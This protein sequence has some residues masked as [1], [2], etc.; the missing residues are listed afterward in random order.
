MARWLRILIIEL[1]A[2]FTAAIIAILENA[3]T[4]EQHPKHALIWGLVAF[5]A[6][7][8]VGQAVGRVLSARRDDQSAA[9]IHGIDATA[10]SIDTTTKE[11]LSLQSSAISE[12]DELKDDRAIAK[13]PYVIRSSVKSLWKESPQEVRRV[14]R[15]VNEPASRPA[16]V[17]TEWGQSLP[18][19]LADSGWSALAAAGELAQAYGVNTLASDL[20]LRSAPDSTRPQYWTARAAY[21]TYVHEGAQAASDLL[22]AHNIDANS[23]DMFARII[24]CLSNHENA[25]CR[26]LIEE[27]DPQLPVDIFLSGT[28]QV[29]LIFGANGSQ[30]GMTDD[31]WFRVVRLYRQLIAKLPQSAALRVGLAS[32]LFNVAVMGISTDRHRDLNEALEQAI[33]ARDIARETFSSSVQAVE[34]ACQAAYN[35]WQFRRTIQLG[36]TI[37]GEATA[38]EERSDIVRTSVAHAAVLLGERDI[39]D[40]LTLEIEDEYRKSILVAMS[41]EVDGHPL[42]HLWESSLRLSRHPHERYLAL[43]GLA[44]MGLLY[45]AQVEALSHELSKEAALINAVAEATAGNLSSAIQRLRSIQGGDLNIVTSLADAYVQAGDTP[46]AIDTLREGAGMLNEPRL[47]VDAARLLDASGDREAAVTELE[48]LVLDS[49]GNGLVQRDALGTLQ[50]SG[51]FRSYPVLCDM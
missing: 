17:L 21:I 36:T 27:W 7:T 11:I 2:V 25:T 26:T 37:T 43:L 38:E 28:C 6:L 40:R 34:I 8:A 15:S 9:E 30:A 39:A 10:R 4:N 51:V 19:W 14:I 18:A 41:A 5:L 24:F 12:S 33:T 46:A 48:Q 44:R 22:A 29:Q 42:A 50:G 23:T 1:G 47:R 16:A 3:L 13:F 45:S 20:F 35:D 31:D 49:A 32:T